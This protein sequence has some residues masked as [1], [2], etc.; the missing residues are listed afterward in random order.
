MRTTVLSI[1]AH[2]TDRWNVLKE[3]TNSPRISNM[4]HG[5][6]QFLEHSDLHL[7][8]K[9]TIDDLKKEFEPIFDYASTHDNPPIINLGDLADT[10]RE[11]EYNTWQNNDKEAIELS[12]N[13]FKNFSK[14]L[15]TVPNLKYYF[16]FG[17]H[18]K[19]IFDAGVDP[20]EIMNEHCNNLI[21]L[22][23]EKGSFIVGNDKIGVFHGFSNGIRWSDAIDEI[24]PE[25]A[26]DG[27]ILQSCI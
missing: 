24:L 4:F 2:A 11:I 16:L 1:N 27:V 22:G 10:L 5:K 13:F 19:H 17:N 6:L 7:N 26:T 25:L 21:P 20:L 9:S 14:V 12:I 8:L 23:A 15:G 18:E 3:K